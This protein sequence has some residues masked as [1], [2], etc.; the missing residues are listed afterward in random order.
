MLIPELTKI[1]Y[2]KNRHSP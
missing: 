2:N 1:S